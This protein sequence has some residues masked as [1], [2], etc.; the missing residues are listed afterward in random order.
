MADNKANRENRTINDFRTT[1]DL[2][3]ALRS[4]DL[5]RS[6]TTN[7]NYVNLASPALLNNLTDLVIPEATIEEDSSESSPNPPPALDSKLDWVLENYDES[8]TTPQ[9]LEE[10]LHRLM[11]LKSYLILD[12]ERTE[13][14]ERVT[15][16]A[17]RFF[18]C[19]IALISLVDLGRQWFL[20]NRGL[21]EIRE[22]SRKLAFCAHA[23][24]SNEDLLIVPDATKDFRFKDSPLVTG[25]PNIRFYAGAP[26]ISPE[27][28]KLGTLCVIDSKPRPEGLSLEEKQNLRELAALAVQSIVDHKRNKVDEHND[29][30]QLIAHAA[31]DLLTPLTGVQLSLSLLKEDEILNSHLSEHQKE[32]ISTAEMC[33]NVMGRICQ[34]AIDSY[35]NK[36]S[37]AN[38]KDKTQKAPSSHVV[39]SEF[40]QNIQ[41][42]MEP[43]PKQVPLYIDVD[44]SVPDVVIMDDLKVFRSA[45][46]FLTNACIQT[47]TG[48]IRLSI[49]VHEMNEK[50]LLFECEDTGPGVSADVYPN[51]FKPV[52][53]DSEEGYGAC[54]KPSANGG[55]EPVTQMQTS[56]DG[57]GLYSVALHV[58]SLGGE[59]GF[60]PR[61][62]NNENIT[63]NNEVSGSIF[64]FK[65]PLVTPTDESSV[66]MLEIL[67][68][69]RSI[70]SLSLTEPILVDV[71]GTPSIPKDM[72]TKLYSSFTQ[73]LEGTGDLSMSNSVLPID[74]A[75]VASSVS[76]GISCT[77]G[78]TPKPKPKEVPMVQAV[79]LAD[80]GSR[81]KKALV[82]DDSLVV[83]KGLAR[84]LTKLG[85]ETEQAVDGM[86]GLAA[87]KRSLYDV[88]LCDFLMPVMDGLDCV[89]QYREWE[90][91]HRSFFRQHIIGISA[92]GGD[93]DIAKGMEVGMDDFKPK[94]VTFK[95]LEELAKSTQI[96]EVGEKLDEIAKA[97]TMM[98]VA[99]PNDEEADGPPGTNDTITS[100][101]GTHNEKAQESTKKKFHFCLIG[102][103]PGTYTSDIEAVT[104]GRGWKVAFAYSGEEA[105][106]LMRI[107]NWDAVFLDEELPILPPIQCVARFREWE[108]QNRV[109]KQ[110]FITLLSAGCSPMSSESRNGV[111]GFTMFTSM[112]SDC[113]VLGCGVL[114]TSLC[115]QIL[116]EPELDSWHVTAIT[117]TTDH[118]A[119]IRHFLGKDKHNLD[120]QRFT[121]QTLQDCH[122][123]PVKYKNMVFCV[124]PS[125]FPDYAAAVHD[126]VTRYWA[127]PQGGGSFI[128]TSSGGIYG[129]DLPG[130]DEKIPVVNEETPVPGCT[131]PVKNPPSARVQRLCKAEEYVRENGGTCLR[132]AGLY[133]AT[134]GA[135]NY[136]LTSGKEIPG[137]PDGLINLLHYDDAAGAV[138]A[139]LKADPPVVSGKTFLISDGNPMT[140]EQICVSALRCFAYSGCSLPKFLG[141]RQDPVG[142]R[143]DGS[144]SN[145]VLQW[146]PR[147]A[148]F[149]A[150]LADERGI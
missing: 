33:T 68:K 120:S 93:N 37:A 142:K 35:R 72:A 3:A 43:F 34:S 5:Q 86:E 112:I 54:M 44:D 88:V 91:N 132:L 14:F 106:R 108:E 95:Q 125:G 85:Y 19:P 117:R 17:S 66:K 134:R 131:D 36:T 31:H 82:I 48:S 83:R 42:V 49:S 6:Q 92:H 114:G 77:K 50:M 18:R 22:T 71:L 143:F 55:F 81:L 124:P 116:E 150:C 15:G 30:S 128:F 147:Y 111:Y 87:L 107:R 148:S 12:S 61:G 84:V 24:M 2:S 96:V 105:L 13:S 20:S 11:V 110:R 149:A 118:H 58:S 98:V 57:L 10:E 145:A 78:S 73:V 9:T 62:S 25:E 102:V 21:G 104:T 65:I 39:I 51:L 1:D 16:L 47:E 4:M 133:T 52:T 80:G 146:K 7:G 53:N 23:I 144:L 59:Y 70:D 76:G 130:M 63:E 109:T 113:A 135:H 26:L 38:T 115:K 103:K 101:N 8:I 67:P 32:M 64:W 122:E 99:T 123:Q 141:S 137:R 126:A 75:S 127:G 60:R 29:P 79:E 45:V 121:L 138:L 139:A 40:V 28:Y 140:R 94:P 136:W 97:G 90:Q 119:S 129:Q 27:G 46:N 69:R 100:N 41:F 56:S 89:Q 74:S